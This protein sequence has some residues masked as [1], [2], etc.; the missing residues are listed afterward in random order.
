[1]AFMNPFRE[2][3][4]RREPLYE[5]LINDLIRL[6]VIAESETIK[7]AKDVIALLEKPIE[8]VEKKL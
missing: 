7:S 3:A 5:A 8:A 4:M 1:M 2:R 6:G